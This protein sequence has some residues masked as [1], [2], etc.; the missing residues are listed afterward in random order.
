MNATSSRRNSRLLILLAAATVVSITARLGYWQLSRAADKQAL[1]AALDER[2]GLPAL[3]GR[4]LANSPEAAALQHFRS[5]RLQGRWLADKTVLLDNRPMG[6]RVGFVVITPLQLE[7][8][9]GAVVVQ[10]GWLP[11]NSADRAALPPFE[12]P[13]G[14]VDVAGWVAP[15]P[16]RLFE[17][18]AVASGPIRQNLDLPEYAR[19][20]RL[21]LAPL[22]IQES[23]SPHTAGD[24]LLRNWSRPAIGIQKNYGYAAQWFA[25]AALTAG[26]YVWFQWV[27]PWR[28]LAR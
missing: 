19:E 12:T 14:R 11:R 27:Q 23:D 2:S 5:V 8:G 28:R 13:G 24:G 26:L 17:F 1:Q 20:T 15:A 18:A 21:A 22:S 9:P 3:Q 6:G 10:R 16:S 25:L 4:E 7:P